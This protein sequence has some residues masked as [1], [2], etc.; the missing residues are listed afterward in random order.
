MPFTIPEIAEDDDKFFDIRFPHWLYD[1]IGNAKI[2]NEREDALD[3]FRF[4]FD[5]LFGDNNFELGS[6]L[7]YDDEIDLLFSSD[8]YDFS[9]SEIKYPII[10]MYMH[11]SKNEL[12][13][14]PEFRLDNLHLYELD[15]SL[16]EFDKLVRNEFQF[17]IGLIQDRLNPDFISAIQYEHQID[18]NIDLD[19]NIT[20]DSIFFRSIFKS[21]GSMWKGKP[22]SPFWALLFHYKLKK[23]PHPLFDYN[24]IE[25]I[26]ESILKVF[27]EK[28]KDVDL[29]SELNDRI[30]S[31][32]ISEKEKILE[33]TDHFL[34]E[35]NKPL[36]L[37]E[38]ETFL[39]YT[40]KERKD[41][42]ELGQPSTNEMQILQYLKQLELT[43]RKSA[44]EIFTNKENWQFEC[45]PKDVRIAV[46]EKMKRKSERG[47][48]LS[49]DESFLNATDFGQL[50]E[51]FEKNWKKFF[52]DAFDD[53]YGVILPT[54][55]ELKARYRDPIAHADESMKYSEHDVEKIKSFFIEIL[56]KHGNLQG[57]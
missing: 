31:M 48:L 50:I 52:K 15:C 7:I 18:M 23:N 41:G 10:G 53:Q 19:E 12:I 21:E 56:E 3:F 37:P 36:E 22:I 29:V 4:L 49:N 45:V 40:H 16:E 9:S 5:A 25:K 44:L 2:E 13:I 42:W 51:I 6:W 20:G 11:I 26:F 24:K 54:L 35:K 34:K 43:L 33:I 1:E 17:E 47:T 28:R 27:N 14:A 30:K 39:K 57:R 32:N 55:K 8:K 46:K 38:G